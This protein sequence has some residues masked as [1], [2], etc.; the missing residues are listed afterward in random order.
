MNL[1]LAFYLGGVAAQL[2]FAAG[3][4]SHSGHHIRELLLLTL[5]WPLFAFLVLTGAVKTK[6]V[7]MQEE[8]WSE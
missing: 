4:R 1:I 5:G 7:H 3:V 2:P 6:A 8:D